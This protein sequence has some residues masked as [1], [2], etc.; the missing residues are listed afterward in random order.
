MPGAPQ[1]PVFSLLSNFRSSAFGG[2]RLWGNK[3]VIMGAMW[4]GGSVAQRRNRKHGLYFQQLE[5]EMK[6]EYLP[7]L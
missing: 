1:K 3:S 5:K 6:T 2:T 4:T 7:H